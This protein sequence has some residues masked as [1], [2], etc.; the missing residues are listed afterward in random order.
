MFPLSSLAIR[1][2]RHHKLRNALTALAI[3]VAIALVVG[4]GSAFESA[5][6]QVQGTLSAA[7]GPVDILV[8]PTDTNSTMDASLVTGIGKIDGVVA[9]AGRLGGDAG[10]WKGGKKYQA[11]IIGV[12]EDDFI[13]NDPRFTRITG[14]RSLGT[15]G[16]VVDSRMGIPVGTSVT[17]RGY[18]FKVVGLY[19][20]SMESDV[21]VSAS[22]YYYAF[23]GLERA[24]STFDEADS[25]DYA[26]VKVVSLSR[27][28]EIAEGIRAKYVSLT[29]FEVKKA[30]A[31]KATSFTSSF[32]RSLRFMAFIAFVLGSFIC[33]NTAYLNV[34]ERKHE[35]GLLRAVGASRL[36]IFLMFLAESIIISLLGAAA[37]LLLGEGLT[38]GFN[39]YLS[40]LYNMNLSLPPPDPGMIV[41]VV[42]LGLG[43]ALLGGLIPSID[44]SRMNVIRA[45]QHRTTPGYKPEHLKL[46]IF[47]LG[48]GL[49]LAGEYVAPLY[50][51]YY[52]GSVDVFSLSL[53]ATG[54]VLITVSLLE[55]LSHVL[56]IFTFLLVGRLSELPV[57]NIARNLGKSALCLILITVCL[58]FV[59]AIGGMEGTVTRSIT[60][61]AGGFFTSDLILYSN[62]GFP[63]DFPNELSSRYPEIAGLAG[64]RVVATDVYNPNREYGRLGN[65]SIY[66]QILTVDPQAFFSIIQMSMSTDTPGY[67]AGLLAKDRTCLITRTL[68]ESIH[69]GIGDDLGIKTVDS[70]YD[71][72]KLAY[73]DVPKMHKLRIVGI[74][75]DPNMGFL[76]FGG[77]PFDEMV[78]TSFDSLGSLYANALEPPDLTI[79]NLVF[80]KV[81]SGYVTQIQS[82]KESILER[83]GQEYNLNIYT[84]DDLVSM[85]KG[86]IDNIFSLFYLS[87]AFSLVVAAIGMANVMTISVSERSREIYLLRAIGASR[88]QVSFSFYAETFALSMIGLIVGLATGLLFW[89]RLSASFLAPGTSIFSI[90]PLDAIEWA[91]CAVIGVTIVSGS[92]PAWKASKILPVGRIVGA[93][94]RKGRFESRRLAKNGGRGAAR[95]SEALFG[96]KPMEGP[97]VS[98]KEEE[99]RLKEIAQQI[100]EGLRLKHPPAITRLGVSKDEQTVAK[101]EVPEPKLEVSPNLARKLQALSGESG[102]L[103]FLVPDNTTSEIVESILRLLPE[104]TSVVEATTA[105][106]EGQGEKFVNSIVILRY[107]LISEGVGEFLADVPKGSFR[108]VLV[109]SSTYERLPE[110]ARSL[111]QWSLAA[112]IGQKRLKKAEPRSGSDPVPGADP[113]DSNVEG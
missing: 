85:V 94:E 96:K 14:D 10:L 13:Y 1:N 79:S 42:E 6:F 22:E 19:S 50:S 88:R 28:G 99:A 35:V 84:R 3:C 53:V 44:A 26:L 83:Y 82:L 81:S 89:S 101:T 67:P 27:I 102:V 75:D 92:Y 49:I 37:G 113:K 4:L 16:I 32:Y 52:V 77:R 69:M 11:H 74:I 78:I 29:V 54:A 8:R 25:I 21:T 2:L 62:T 104:G 40:S 55:P 107:G 20:P 45:I 95:L 112:Q 98:R 110:A 109:P 56:R 80:I 23:I 17:I 68:A 103:S 43:S 7:S 70:V 34:I 105:E 97:V 30:V 66:S 100:R 38:L 86:N 59:I 18:A 64:V 61:T 36:Q 72:V 63:T 33:F 58:T 65:S 73:T 9:V 12:A 47:L 57:N 60:G 46:L 91:F 76:L 106:I 41:L 87:L 93:P 71:E 108:V 31:E 51:V 24:Q 90:L 48:L 111:I 5:Y 15:Y 39:V